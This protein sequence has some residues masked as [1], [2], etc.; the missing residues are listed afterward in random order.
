MLLILQGTLR[1]RPSDWS[2]SPL[3]DYMLSLMD[4]LYARLT[5]C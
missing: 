5:A 4:G 3:A 1:A 2:T